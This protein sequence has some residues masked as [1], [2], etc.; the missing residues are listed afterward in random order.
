MRRNMK[1][2]TWMKSDEDRKHG[3]EEE[4]V[5]KLDSGIPH[6]FFFFSSCAVVCPPLRKSSKIGISFRQQDR[7]GRRH[8]P[9]PASSFFLQL[10][11]CFPVPSYFRVPCSPVLTS[12][13]KIRIFTLIELLIV[14][15][16]IAILAA[17]LLPALNSAKNKAQAITCTSQKK[18]IFIF[19]P[20]R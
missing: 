3:R 5:K 6:S 12:R 18:Q 8:S 10:F 4:R 2:F 11:K 17:M 1:L 9:D 14:I 15:A 7:A 19:K 16:V 20:E 13:M